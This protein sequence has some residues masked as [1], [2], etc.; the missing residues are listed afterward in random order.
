MY[1]ILLI[2]KLLF[3]LE[4]G[5]SDRPL[6]LAVRADGRT[7]CHHDADWL[8]NWLR[9]RADWLKVRLWPSRPPGRGRAA[10]RGKRRHTAGPPGAD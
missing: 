3:G 6:P 2:L 4:L 1:L 9:N 7:H 5:G 10:V 8:W